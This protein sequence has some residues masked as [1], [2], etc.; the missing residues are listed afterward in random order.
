MGFDDHETL[1]ENQQVGIT[2]IGFLG[3]RTDF[4]AF[5]LS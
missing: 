3:K 4:I 2:K 1:K 5:M